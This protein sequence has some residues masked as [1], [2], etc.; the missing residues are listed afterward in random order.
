M[1]GV[2]IENMKGSGSTIRCM[3]REEFSGQTD[4][5]IK[6]IMKMIKS[7]G[8]AHFIGRMEG[9][10]LVVG[11]MESST[12]KVSIFRLMARKNWENGLKEKGSNGLITK[13]NKIR[14][15]LQGILNS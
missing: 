4:G 7:M 15:C 11:K 6:D 14:K 2:R 5:N 12:G 13:M 1:Y 3:E 10:M 9:S 8:K